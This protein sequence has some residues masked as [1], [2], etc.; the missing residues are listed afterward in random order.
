MR[1]S[2]IDAGTWQYGQQHET[3]K[4]PFICNGDV[5]LPTRDYTLFDMK[6]TASNFLELKRPFTDELLTLVYPYFDIVVRFMHQ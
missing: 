1:R 3:I 6:S 5:E 2:W 4:R